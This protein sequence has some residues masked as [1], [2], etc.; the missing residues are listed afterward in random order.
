MSLAHS[1]MTLPD[2]NSRLKDILG[3]PTFGGLA[4]LVHLQPCDEARLRN[5]FFDRCRD[6]DQLERLLKF[7]P[8]L[9]VVA[10]SRASMRAYG[11][12]FWANFGNAIGVTIPVPHRAHITDLFCRAAHATFPGYERANWQVWKHA[13]EFLAQAGLPLDRCAKFAQALRNAVDDTGLPEPD[14]VEQI[15][16]L[17]ARMLERFELQ[18]QQI[19]RRALVGPSGLMLVQAAAA[20]VQTNDFDHFNS[21]FGGA[22]R[23][24]FQHLPQ[25]TAKGLTLRRPYVRLASDLNGF[26]LCAPFPPHELLASSG[27]Q[28]EI[29]GQRHQVPHGE[30]LVLPIERLVPLSVVLRGLENGRPICWSLDPRPSSDNKGFAAFEKQKRRMTRFESDA[31]GFSL[32]PGDYVLAHGLGWQCNDASDRIEWNEQKMALSM[33]SLRPGRSVEF[34]D[35]D[36]N[37]VHI[38]ANCSVWLD[39]VGQSFSTT[40]GQIRV[41]FG[42]TEWPKVWIP[43]DSDAA[44]W[45]VEIYVMGTMNSLGLIDENHQIGGLRRCS[46][47][48]GIVVESLDSRLHHLTIVIRHGPRIRHKQEIHYWAGLLE[49]NPKNMRWTSTP[50]NLD[51]S[52]TPGFDHVENGL[53][54]EST[55]DRVRSL[56]FQC[57]EPVVLRWLRDGVTLESCDLAGSDSQRWKSHPLGASF[58]ADEFSKVRLRISV[59]PVTC[60]CLQ[61]NGNRFNMASSSGGTIRFDLSLATI[62]ALHPEGGTIS[63]LIDEGTDAVSVASF[64]P[65][66]VALRVIFFE[67]DDFKTMKVLLAA[68]PKSARIIVRN[69]LSQERH[70]IEPTPPRQPQSAPGNPFSQLDSAPLLVPNCPDGDQRKLWFNG[71]RMP[72]ML[73]RLRGAMTIDGCSGFSVEFSAPHENWKPGI[74]WIELECKMSDSGDWAPLRGHKRGALPIICVR[75]LAK[76][77]TIYR[78]VAM[79]LAF[80]DRTQ[81]GFR[82]SKLELCDGLEGDVVSCYAEVRSLL[83]ER[84]DAASWSQMQ[85]LVTL[86]GLLLSQISYM[87][88][89]R[90]S[91][92]TAFVLNEVN[93]DESTADARSMLASVAGVLALQAEAMTGLVDGDHLRTCLL[94]CARLGTS[95]NPADGFHRL[96]L[97]PSSRLGIL[98]VEKA[99]VAK[100][101]GK[102]GRFDFQS[103]FSCWRDANTPPGD[104]EWLVPLSSQHFAWAVARFLSRR[105]EAQ[106]VTSFSNVNTLFSKAN[107]IVSH[108]G[109]TSEA[110]HTLLPS[111]VRTRPWPEVD[112][113]DSFVENLIAFASVYALAARLAGHEQL[114]FRT[115]MKWLRGQNWLGADHKQAVSQTEMTLICKAPELLGFFLM[116][117]QL[118]LQTRLNQPSR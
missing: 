58:A 46:I 100:H 3:S 43:E 35:E 26:E 13:G 52:A 76:E 60:A 38:R 53:V 67:S 4:G 91:G 16:E 81:N 103:C 110:V 27:V 99:S 50:T 92:A 68:Q 116:F 84:V 23:E 79:L 73:C 90:S 47:T 55:H 51:L 1:F 63:V 19:I 113:S 20:A 93:A 45:L 65:P 41:H 18:G 14:D 108:L 107:V 36:E 29:N 17:T 86:R 70:V 106:A 33:I 40:D 71:E 114:S 28:W 74:W 6:V 12:N 25:R 21:E 83:N 32:P 75:N 34:S 9:S 88:D 11:D 77:S 62:A 105:D 37:S 66:V 24:A 15:G 42:W 7:Q 94:W 87:L 85:G 104:P 61:V 72:A 96:E 54:V 5:E 117:W 8:A 56:R 115:F 64:R 69:I 31:N 22:L 30:S 49:H 10:L 101:F 48:P 82:P 97:E 80:A 102:D 89:R 59:S 111:A 78:E 98:C 39:P 2:T 112:T 44:N 57:F 118:I 109:V 95:D